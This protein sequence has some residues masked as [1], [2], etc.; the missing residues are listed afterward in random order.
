[1]TQYSYRINR[2]IHGIKETNNY[3][4]KS[5]IEDLDDT[6]NEGLNLDDSDIYA[7][8]TLKDKVRILEVELQK[9]REE[10]FQAGYQEGKEN[11]LQEAN[12]RI[13]DITNKMQELENNF[14]SAVEKLEGPVLNLAK[15]MAGV[16]LNSELQIRNDH[17]QI[18]LTKLRDMLY[19]MIDQ[20][21][22]IIKL[23]PEQMG[24]LKNRDLKEE[25][26]LP[27]QMELTPIADPNLKNG[28]AVVQTEE[29]F[30]DGS[31]K[32]QLD[33]VENQLKDGDSDV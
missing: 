33:Q 20:N 12:R 9:A 1:M 7:I 4:S 17:D 18:L 5:S 8:K 29:F 30:V 22:V 14:V 24:R 31:F 32:G 2:P 11:T 23:S 26:G 25:M 13:T 16:I 3:R 15:R 6:I 10:S 19:Q 28:E 27:N 21:K